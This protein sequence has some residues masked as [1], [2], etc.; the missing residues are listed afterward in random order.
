[1]EVFQGIDLEH[2]TCKDF[3]Q[4]VLMVEFHEQARLYFVANVDDREGHVT[5]QFESVV[6][7]FFHIVG[8]VVE[9]VY[10]V[11][12]VE[13]TDW[14]EVHVLDVRTS[15]VGNEGFYL[16]VCFVDASK[17]CLQFVLKNLEDKTIILNHSDFRG[18][19][20][21]D[22]AQDRGGKL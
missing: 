4:A 11:S 3:V 8:C 10:L 18:N 21:A 2:C 22:C 9:P 7:A 13:P 14:A 17:Y 20:P 16:L 5:L 15:E 6:F 1:M 19:L 12:S